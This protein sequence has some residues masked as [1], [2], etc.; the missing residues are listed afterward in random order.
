MKKVCILTSVHSPFDTRIF[1]KQA[2]SLLKAGYDV[3]LIAQHE[4]DEVVDGIKIVALPKSRNRFW[5]ILGNC[6]VF[7]LALKQKADIY[8]FHDPELLPWGWLL[9]KLRHKPVIYDVHENLINTI[10][11]KL[12]I[13]RFLRRPVAWLVDIVERALASRLAAII[14]ISE[15]MKPRFAG[16]R[17][18]CIPVRNFPNLE[19][20]SQALAGHKPQSGAKRYSII[21]NGKMSQERGFRIILEAMDLVVKQ[22][23]EAVCAILG[24]AESYGWLDKE[25]LNLM[26]RL[27]KQGNLQIIGRVPHQEVFQYLEVSHIG[28]KPRL[29]YQEALDVTVFEYMA[30]ALP[31][32]ASDVPL[33]NDIIRKSRCGIIIAPGDAKAHAAAILYLLEHPAEA[34]KMGAK[35]KKAV[36]EKYNWETESKK[37]LELYSE[38]LGGSHV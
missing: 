34:K 16:C 38:L 35:G 11:F 37:L 1:H 24:D 23:P 22:K 3:T 26:N 9:Q 32:V 25:G 6:R 33:I 19:M 21:H 20:I 2:K 29:H 28:W 8:H 5:R 14:T 18:I 27:I 36:F 4:R 17:G 15:P 30:C 13:P 7:R 10:P 31:I 12:W